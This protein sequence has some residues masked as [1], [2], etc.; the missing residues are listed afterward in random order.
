MRARAT[1]QLLHILGHDERVGEELLG[2]AGGLG[3]RRRRQGEGPGQGGRQGAQ[4][5]P[6]R[7]AQDML[8]GMIAKHV[9]YRERVGCGG[10]TWARAA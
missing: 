1:A 2:A 8:E 6:A 9:R 3:G 4:Y 10:R 7:Q 5:D